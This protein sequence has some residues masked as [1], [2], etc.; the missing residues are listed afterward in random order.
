MLRMRR[1]YLM[2]LMLGI[3]GLTVGSCG[4]PLSVETPRRFIPVDIDSVLLSEPFLEKKSDSLYAV[5]DGRPVTFNNIQRPAQYNQQKGTGWY[6]SVDGIRFFDQKTEEY[7]VLSLRLDAISD[8][9]TYQMR[10]NYVIPKEIDQSSPNEYSGL[11]AQLTGT[12]LQSFFSAPSASGAGTATPDGEIRIVGFNSDRN[13]IVG[14]F[15][16]TGHSTAD[17]ATIRVY[18]GIFRLQLKP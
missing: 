1:L 3:S 2:F 14:T 17:D 10:G 11:Y 8:T 15:R 16:F 7:E 12:G 9:G 13:A 6:L 5:I 18:D 4:D